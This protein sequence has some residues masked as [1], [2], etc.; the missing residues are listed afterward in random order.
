MRLTGRSGLLPEQSL[1]LSLPIAV[2]RYSSLVA[3]AASLNFR[4]A[5]V[6][7]RRK[8]Q[9]LY[10]LFEKALLLALPFFFFCDLTLVMLLLAFC[11]AD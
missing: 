5:K 10:F 2:F 9:V 11:Q 8:R 4:F 7:L 6:S 1:L 3:S